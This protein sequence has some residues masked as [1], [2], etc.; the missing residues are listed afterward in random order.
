LSASPD[1]SVVAVLREVIQRQKT[2]AGREDPAAFETL[3][4]EFHRRM[5]EAAA[6]SDLY[7]LVRQRSGH[8]DRIRRLH[9]P[10]AGKMPEIVRD[11][12]LIV[13]AIAAGDAA[14]AKVRV[15]EHLSRSL[16]YSPALRERHPDYFKT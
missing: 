11:H 1:K 2:A 15:R 16:A 13:E 12:G 3:D 6:V 5:F 8:I 14:V 7:T 4:L 9:L 10:V